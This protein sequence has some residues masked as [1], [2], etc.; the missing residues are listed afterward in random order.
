MPQTAGH[1]EIPPGLLCAAR[2]L[3]IL[4]R[5]WCQIDDPAETVRLRVA[6]RWDLR[7]EPILAG[8]SP[9]AWWP[10]AVGSQTRRPVF[11]FKLLGLK[12]CD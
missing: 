8:E 11:R 4:S 3:R 1:P 6:F 2:L 10:W 5:V 9:Y 12:A 7:H